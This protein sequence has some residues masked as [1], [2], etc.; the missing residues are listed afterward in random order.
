MVNLGGAISSMEDLSIASAQ[1]LTVDQE[2]KAELGFIALGST[3]G[4]VT[5]NVPINTVIGVNIAAKQNVL[6]K[7]IRTFG[8]DV[9]VDAEQ[10]IATIR[11]KVNSRG[12]DV[13]ISALGRVRTKNIISRSGDVFV[14]SDNSFVRTGYIRTDR[15]KRSGDVYLE[16]A[17]NIKVAAS[18]EINGEEYSIFAGDEGVISVAH[19]QNKKENKRSPFVIGDTTR[20]GTLALVT[21]PVTSPPITP[22]GG[23]TVQ[24]NP[25]L[26]YIEIFKRVLDAGGTAP[27][28][29]DEINPITGEA[30]GSESQFELV[31]KFTPN[32]SDEII[33]FVNI[34]KFRLNFE[35][36]DQKGK[37]DTQND[38]GCFAIPLEFHLGDDKHHNQYADDVTGSKGDIIVI[39]PSRIGIFGSTT[40]DGIVRAGS[41]ATLLSPPQIPQNIGDLGEVKTGYKG[42]NRIV[43]GNA[44]PDDLEL[45]N[46]LVNQ[47]IKEATIA[48][49][50]QKEYFISFDIRSVANDARQLLN[51]DPRILALGLTIK[52]NY[53]LSRPLLPTKQNS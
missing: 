29:M 26:I 2:I 20:S 36:I 49:A 43:N 47:V 51:N 27:A 18:V 3:E 50:C 45:Y 17:K 23:G 25:L 21:S 19:Q 16:A 35:Y 1:S 30:Y 41:K 13:S 33:K 22:P 53:I 31:K 46:N 40:Y 34:P 7:K 9:F 15:G 12:G 5:V 10:G 44:F 8:G 6:T 42:L 48:R 4:S 24:P 28:H 14:I 38:T 37:F 39:P 32:Q 11:G 52:V